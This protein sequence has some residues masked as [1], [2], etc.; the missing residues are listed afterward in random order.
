MSCDDRGCLCVCAV[1]M[2]AMYLPWPQ[3]SILL[4]SSCKEVIDSTGR[5]VFRG[6]RLKMGVCE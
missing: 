1:Q 5:L 6:P 2:S 3:S 4:L